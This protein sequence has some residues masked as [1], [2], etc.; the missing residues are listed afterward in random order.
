MN[1]VRTVTYFMF[2]TGVI[3]YHRP[4]KDG[5]HQLAIRI[6]KDRKSSYVLLG[7]YIEK[8]QWDKKT[9]KVRK[10]NPNSARLN[11]FLVKRLAE[12]NKTL[13]TDE[14]EDKDTTVQEI[15]KVVVKKRSKNSFFA[16]AQKYFNNLREEGKYNRYT[17]E[18]PRIERFEI[19]LKGKDVKFQ[20]I[21]VS[22]L[23]QFKAHLKGKYKASERTAVNYMITI[24]TIFNRAIKSG[25]VDQ[26][27]Y[28]F[29]KDKMP[30]RFPD[31][32]K[33]GLSKDELTKLEEVDLSDFP[34]MHH[35]RN[36]WLFSF[37]FAGI[38]VSDVLRL[39][40]SDFQEGRLHY[41]MGKNSKTGS[42]KT[43]EQA[44]LILAQY[45]SLKR[46]TDD[47]IFPE[48]KVVDDFS[49]TYLV[50]RKTSYA[51]KTL[52]K[53]LKR[54][55]EKLSFEKKLTMHIARH[56][57]GNLSGDRI[58]IQMLQKLYRHSDITTTIGY[59]KAFIYKDADDALDAV[60]NS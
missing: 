25:I 19:F 21:T 8:D 48:L 20:E 35:A 4:G 22:L 57:F 59:Q 2:T 51:V 44:Q 18:K 30:V 54:L 16:E 60:L 12:V 42:L 34:K 26:K 45:E 24:R 10:S 58:P 32:E 43:P 47:V 29:G 33:M 13:L 23:E 6:T 36:V 15:H 46:H 41:T 52:N 53:Y 17:S 56:T 14:I 38:R 5:K 31:T 1:N 50:Q 55:G 3:L 37:Y 39:R 27:H 28:P 7:Q 11:A 9:R 40:W 49:D